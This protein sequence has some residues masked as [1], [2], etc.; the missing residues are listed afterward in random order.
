MKDLKTTNAWLSKNYY[1][2]CGTTMRHVLYDNRHRLSSTGYLS[3]E[4]VGS[5]K[6]NPSDEQFFGYQFIDGIQ[7]VKEEEN[8]NF[9]VWVS[10]LYYSTGNDVNFRHE[11]DI[12]ID[13]WSILFNKVYNALFEHNVSRGMTEQYISENIIFIYTDYSGAIA[14]LMAAIDISNNKQIRQILLQLHDS[15]CEE[16]EDLF[17]CVKLQGVLKTIYSLL[18]DVFRI[19]QVLWLVFI[20]GDSEVFINI[21]KGVSFY[22]SNSGRVGRGKILGNTYCNPPILIKLTNLFSTP[23]V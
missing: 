8:Y 21:D 14:E 10:G 17:Y 20:E 11:V 1:R 7:L 3:F 4:E 2:D 12:P 16:E 15:R 13:V 9:V 18:S 6:L 23:E 19:Q 5:I 22:H